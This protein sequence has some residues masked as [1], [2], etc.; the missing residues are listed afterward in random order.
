[1]IQFNAQY[2]NSKRKISKPQFIK[3]FASFVGNTIANVYSII[4]GAA[5][6]VRDTNLVEYTELSL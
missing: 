6:T 1:L 3:N 4:K 5:I 2:E